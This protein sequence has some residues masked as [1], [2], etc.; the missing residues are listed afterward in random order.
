VGETACEKFDQALLCWSTREG[1][2]SRSCCSGGPGASASAVAA[3]V[4]RACICRIAADTAASTELSIQR[5]PLSRRR[6]CV[7]S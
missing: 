1:M 5:I 2:S 3:R 6:E 4:S 7:F